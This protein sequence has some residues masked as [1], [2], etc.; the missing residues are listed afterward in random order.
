MSGIIN[1]VGA[2]SGIISGGS[3]TS[4]GTRTL[5]GI[6]GLDYEEGTWTP[7]YRND[8]DATGVTYVTSENKA[9][10]TKVGRQ[11]NIYGRVALTNCGSASGSPRVYGLPFTC[12][13]DDFSIYPV[14]LYYSLI[15]HS[16]SV[17]S[18]IYKGEAHFTVAEVNDSGSRTDLSNSD[19]DN[20]TFFGFSGSYQI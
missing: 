13:S 5:A 14:V 12:S 10:Y 4:A 20:N 19:V 6:T 9:Y 1:Q 8:A 3:S 17:Q 18:Y 2:R 15:T 7:D 16:G 11:I